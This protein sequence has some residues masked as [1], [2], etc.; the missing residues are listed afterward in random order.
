MNKVPPSSHELGVPEEPKRHQRGEEDEDAGLV[1]AD[2]P[3]VVVLVAEDAAD[4]DVAVVVVAGAVGLAEGVGEADEPDLQP[5]P[6]QE[7]YEK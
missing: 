4:A 1:R 2:G 5:H 7:L 3:E 6:A